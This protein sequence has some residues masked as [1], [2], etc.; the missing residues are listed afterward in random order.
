ME[1]VRVSLNVWQWKQYLSAEL[2]PQAG[3]VRLAG[4]T[5]DVSCTASAE[6]GHLLRFSLEID[7]TIS[8]HTIR[9]EWQPVHF[10]GRRPWWRCPSCSTRCV[11]LYLPRVDSLAC[12]RCFRLAYRVQR[13]SEVDRLHRRMNKTRGRVW[14]E[15][16]NEFEGLSPV[17]PKPPRMHWRTFHRHAEKL[18]ADNHRNMVLFVERVKGFASRIGRPLDL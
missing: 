12:R 15:R 5:A 14:S 1:S 10:G 7:G 18:R 16:A 3:T 2:P 8:S 17:P 13:Q 4:V 11:I 9:V 6:G